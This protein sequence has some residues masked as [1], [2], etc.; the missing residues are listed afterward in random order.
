MTDSLKLNSGNYV[1]TCKNHLTQENIEE[2]I[3]KV[4]IISKTK[5]GSQ[6]L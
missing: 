1:L 5:T 2:S 4:G 3:A 6:R